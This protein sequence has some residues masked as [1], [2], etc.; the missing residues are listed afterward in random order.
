MQ[1]YTILKQAFDKIIDTGLTNRVFHSVTKLTNEQ[2][3]TY[4][5]YPSGQDAFTY[6]GI[7]DTKMM[8]VY[9]RQIDDLRAGKVEAV[10]GCGQYIYRAVIPH[11]MVFFNDYEKRKQDDLIARFIDFVFTPQ[12]KLLKVI[13][14]KDKLANLESTAK[15]F[16][17]GNETFYAA[18]DFEVTVELKRNK[19]G[20]EIG[21]E[22]INNPYTKN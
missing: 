6:V 7:D 2:G 4:P 12:I 1:G 11:R 15:G 5:V 17:F 21:C 18:I 9:C 3:E 16:N 13:V 10:G 20:D 19:C 14:D 8:T 22:Q